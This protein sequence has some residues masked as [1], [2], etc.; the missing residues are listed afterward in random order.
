MHHHPMTHSY[1]SPTPSHQQAGSLRQPSSPGPSSQLMGSV[2]WQQQ[3]L[4]AE[5]SIPLCY[6]RFHNF[7]SLS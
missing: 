4:K 6:W 2:H 5:V 7:P 1:T 3:M